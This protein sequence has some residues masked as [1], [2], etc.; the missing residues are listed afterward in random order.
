MAYSGAV[1]LPLFAIVTLLFFWQA[2]PSGAGRSAGILS[3]KF[4]GSM[5]A[6][7]AAA[8]SLPPWLLSSPVDVGALEVLHHPGLG[9]PEGQRQIHRR[10]GPGRREKALEVREDVAPVDTMTARSITFSS[11]RTLPGHG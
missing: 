5:S 8:V 2:A 6:C 3:E 10:V 7:L 1:L 4:L 9:V 11:S